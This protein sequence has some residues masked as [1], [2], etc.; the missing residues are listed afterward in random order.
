MTDNKYWIYLETLRKRGI[1]NM[2]GA[3]PYL[4]KA[5][6]ISINEARNILVDW[7]DNYNPE[8]YKED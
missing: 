5:F 7:M 4:Q 8:D 2:Y 1:T 3:A 6:N